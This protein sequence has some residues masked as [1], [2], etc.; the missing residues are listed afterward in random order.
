MKKLL[1]LAA[2]PLLLVFVVGFGGFGSL[3]ARAANSGFSQV[4]L[5]ASGNWYLNPSQGSGGLPQPVAGYNG[6]DVSQ[7]VSVDD[8]AL[9]GHYSSP[10]GSAS[11]PVTYY[12]KDYTNNQC[13]TTV[14]DQETIHVFITQPRR[15]L[16][17]VFP[18]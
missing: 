6:H 12:F 5:P 11:Y 18:R 17:P 16:L 14:I 15:R 7:C 9:Q 3:V 8:T 1:R 4:G 2:L 10:S 13:G